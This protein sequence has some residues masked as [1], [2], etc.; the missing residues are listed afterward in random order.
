[1]DEPRYL[2]TVAVDQHPLIRRITRWLRKHGVHK[3]N[4]DVTWQLLE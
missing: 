4:I 1:M 2:V 3:H